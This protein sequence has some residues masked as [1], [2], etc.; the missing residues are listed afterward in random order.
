MKRWRKDA[1]SGSLRDN[2]G[3]L[4]DE[5][6]NSSMTK[7][8]NSLCRILYRIA[9]R[10]AENMDAFT[11]MV[12]QSD[13]LIEQVERIL[14]TKLLE[15][16][17]LNNALKGQLQNPTEIQIPHDD[18]SEALK[19]NCKKRKE[20]VVRRR[21]PV[22]LEV[23]KRDKMN[24]GQVEDCNVEA[25]DLEA[26]LSTTDVIPQIS[27]SNQFI[28]P[29]HFMQ[30][31]YV[32]GHQFGL[33]TAQGFH[34]MNQFGQDSASVLQQTF[35]GSSHLNQSTVPAYTTAEMHALQF[36]G[37]NPQLDHQGSDQAQCN[38]PVWDFL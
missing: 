31:P 36:V 34:V 3:L 18:N 35:P 27:S 17:S 5:D 16:P 29:S 1:K 23:N 21:Q 38:I 12:G 30:G 6:P 37:T 2:D 32:T 9:E 28:T 8:Y 4:F 25:R 24:K 11:I 14:Q 33:T 19:V 13:Q 26:P 22:G 20:A 15:K 10:A 7:R